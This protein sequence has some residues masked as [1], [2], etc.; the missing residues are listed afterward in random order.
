MEGGG[1][2]PLAQPPLPPV[3]LIKLKIIYSKP[4]NTQIKKAKYIESLEF[5]FLI[6]NI[7]FS[8]L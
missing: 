1:Y 5:F 7:Y 3:P 6:N 4:L 2:N 8:L